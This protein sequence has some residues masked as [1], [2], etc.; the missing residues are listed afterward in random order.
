MYITR[1]VKDILIQKMNSFIAVG[2]PF[3]LRL[4]NY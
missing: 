4:F 2:E 1:M 3:Y